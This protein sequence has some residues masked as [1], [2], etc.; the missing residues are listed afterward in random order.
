[1]RGRNRR[2]GSGTSWSSVLIG[3]LA[4]LG[5][6]LILGGIVSA[7][8]GAILAVPGAGG[9]PEVGTSDL[10]GVLVT[11]FIAF[12]VGGYTAGRM[13]SRQGTRHG[14]LVALLALIVT[15]VLSFLGGIAGLGL[16]NDL[17]GVTLSGVPTEIAREGLGTALTLGGVLALLLPFLAGAIGGSWGESTGRSRP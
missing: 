5:A 9:G 13:A 12:L 17:Q 8:V 7:V 2:G 4:S 10:V 6:S 16:V 1:M 14:L 11:V 3:W 15:L